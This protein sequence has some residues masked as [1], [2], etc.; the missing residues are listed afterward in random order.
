[1]NASRLVSIHSSL[2]MAVVVGPFTLLAQEIV[3]V[4]GRDRPMDPALEEVYRVGVVEGEP[5][6]MF[7]QVNHV[8]FDERGN[9]YVFDDAGSLLSPDLRVSVFDP[10]G[11]FARMFGT[12]GEG[13]GEFR[14]PN[15]YAVARDG[16][17]IVR[18]RGHLAYQVFDASGGFVRMI[19]NRAGTTESSG[20]GGV[21]TTTT[22]VSTPIQADP[23]GGA[24]YT[25]AGETTISGFG[26]DGTPPAARLIARHNLDG[27]DVHIETVVRPW[28]PP[29]GDTPSGQHGAVGVTL[30]RTF[31][32]RLLMALL[33][34]GGLVYSDSSAY[35]I[36]VVAADG[37]GMV[38]TIT[39]PFQPTP[40]TARIEGEYKRVM[41]EQDAEGR[42]REGRTTV[43]ISTR[44]EGVGND[45]GSVQ[46]LMQLMEEFDKIQPFYP[47]IP[48]L[49]RLQTT[50]EGRIWVMRQGES[51][52]EDGPID[53]LSADGEYVGTYPAGAMTMPDAFGPEGLAAFVGLDEFDVPSVVV[54]RLPTEV[55]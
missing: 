14:H 27:E 50:W 48:V 15:G 12:N 32:P 18:D 25:T 55:R 39:R 21:V 1:M 36:K 46:A 43:S 5:W 28:Q 33:P 8:A 3:E 49:L 20:G 35:A 45:P 19:R 6:E 29:R 4:T 47:E 41:E 11:A 24:V 30:P 7:S 34:D 40:V 42:R 17:T 9:L 44:G 10:S 52:L 13:P 23:R 26:V 31:E 54:R 51:L 53:V 37:S 38:R 16:T 2:L 22:A